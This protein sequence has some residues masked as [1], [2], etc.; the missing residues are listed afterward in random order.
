MAPQST[1]S[2]LLAF[3]L[4]SDSQKACEIARH[5]GF[6]IVIFDM[7]HGILDEAALDRLL[8]FCDA[9]GLRPYVR[10]SDATQSR[11]QTALDIGAHAVILPQ[12]KDIQHAID[13]VRF[14]KYPPLGLRGIGYS[15][16]MSY[17]AANNDFIERENCNRLCYAMIETPDALAAVAEIARLPCV[18]GLFVG[19]ADLS[20]TRGR[21]VFKASAGDVAD[22]RIVA[23]AAHAAGKRWGA[24]A[25]NP[26]Y[27][28]EAISL[29][30]TLL[31]TAD[32]LSA[33]VAGF[34]LLRQ[35]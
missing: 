12:I 3:W 18:D 11:I 29:M 32:D 14:A 25:A 21:G 28:K 10:V 17:G 15:R 33:L 34:R 30:P 27:R 5:A 2:P 8:P 6:E 20:L 19:P 13:V 4:E 9:L 23:A 35:Q 31:A 22:L 1:D 26:G 16:T 7:E 24:A